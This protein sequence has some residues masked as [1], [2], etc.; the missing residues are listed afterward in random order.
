M[1]ILPDQANRA[2][3]LRSV[4]SCGKLAGLGYLIR[5]GGEKLPWTNSTELIDNSWSAAGYAVTCSLLVIY[6]LDTISSPAYAAWGAW[7][8]SAVAWLN[9]SQ[10]TN[11]DGGPDR[12][13]ILLNAALTAAG[14]EFFFRGALPSVLP[15]AGAIDDYLP[16][17]LPTGLAVSVYAY[18]HYHEGPRSR[19]AALAGACF[20][21]TALLGGVSAAVTASFIAG[22]GKSSIYFYGVMKAK[23]QAKQTRSQVR[24]AERAR[25]K[26]K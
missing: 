23:Q 11:A 10:F 21:A 3:L 8:T 12:P 14:H 26:G 2:A 5:I 17:P 7:H 22:I 19:F 16:M 25:K 18:S 15:V 9:D 20:A 6:L 1:P 24:Q 13:A 4:V